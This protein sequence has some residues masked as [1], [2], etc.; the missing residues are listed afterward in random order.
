MKRL[1]TLVAALAATIAAPAY[2]QN[3]NDNIADYRADL[4]Q[5]CYAGRDIG[6]LTRVSN[7]LQLLGAIAYIG[8]VMG[9]DG[10]TTQG[11][12]RETLA[13]PILAAEAI[14][15][16]NTTCTYE[17]EATS[18]GN[19]SVLGFTFGAERAN[20]YR[21]N[22]RLIARQYLATVAEDGQQVKPWRSAIHKNQI[23]AVLGGAD[24]T[25]ENFFL[26]DNI[27][28]YL[29]EVERFRKAGFGVGGTLSLFSGGAN[30]KRVESFKG[31]RLIVTG[32]PV[33]LKRSTYV[34]TTPA[35]AASPPATTMVQALG[36]VDAQQLAT[37]IAAVALSD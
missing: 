10:T 34:A 32:D 11:W 33:V 21:V 35:I 16:D 15:P 19:V 27:S 37:S 36:A 28:I 8:P 9:P 17:F 4:F 1:L 5:N 2:A 12:T 25:V 18:D 24:S 22:V 7:P 23:L 13:L 31:T 20:L 6:A 30:Y 26:F 14:D 3:L 29:L